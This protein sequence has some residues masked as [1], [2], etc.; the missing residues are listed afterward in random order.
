MRP[1]LALTLL[2]ILAPAA[3][4]QEA[5]PNGRKLHERGGNAEEARAWESVVAGLAFDE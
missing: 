1:S 5:P 4:P 2:L 3:L